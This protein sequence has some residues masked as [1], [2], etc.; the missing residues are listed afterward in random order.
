V[1]P[2]HVS[3]PTGT[4]RRIVFTRGASTTISRTSAASTASG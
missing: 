3:S 2:G 1:L 4:A